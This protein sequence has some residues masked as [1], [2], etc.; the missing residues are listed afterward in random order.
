M[1]EIE[2][3]PDHV[4]LL[5]C[6]FGLVCSLVSMLAINSALT[7]SLY[8]PY[9]LNA[10]ACNKKHV[11]RTKLRSCQL[12]VVYTQST[13]SEKEGEVFETEISQYV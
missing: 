13:T 1:I 11:I 6:L 2:F 4:T 7:E 9:N 10:Q 3:R 8:L 5:G 12:S